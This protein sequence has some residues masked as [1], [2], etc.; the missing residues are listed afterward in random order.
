MNRKD[1]CE[2]LDTLMREH[3]G[4]CHASEF[5]EYGT[6][7]WRDVVEAWASA[8][9]R[10]G[11]SLD[12]ALSA[13]QEMWTE[14]VPFGL[15]S[16]VQ[17]VVNHAPLD[18]VT[19]DDEDDEDYRPG[20]V[21]WIGSLSPLALEII[22]KDAKLLLQNFGYQAY[23]QSGWWGI[24]RVQAKHRDW[25][26]CRVCGSKGNLEV[27]HITYERICDESDEDLTTLCRECHSLFHQHHKLASSPKGINP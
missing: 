16:Q 23:L 2:M 26:M 20:G 9:R 7:E 25:N 17:F 3:A 8:L 11:V 21:G 27:H 18:E 4:K 5:P 10:R 12:G 14:G 24:K 6:K 19:D 22:K 15:K 1:Y 13:F